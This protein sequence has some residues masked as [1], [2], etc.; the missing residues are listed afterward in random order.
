MARIY[1]ISL[2]TQGMIETLGRQCGSG[3]A[4]RIAI[5]RWLWL[6]LTT[7]KPPGAKLAPEACFKGS[8]LP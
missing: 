2:Q 4:L 5:H 1:R 6:N 3:E 7:N 8:Q